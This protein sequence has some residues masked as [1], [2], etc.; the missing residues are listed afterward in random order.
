MAGTAST[1]AV[2]VPF[3]EPPYLCGLPSPYYTPE[4]RQ[5]Q[6]ACRDFISEH[7]MPYA[8]EWERDE[9]VPVHLF[10]TFSKHRMLIPTLPSPLPVKQLKACGIHDILGVVKV[11]VGTPFTVLA[12][13]SAYSVSIRTSHTSTT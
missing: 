1:D 3:S 6:K 2:P 10:E 12:D 8:M 9:T 11:E 5:W 4:L 13:C 7:M